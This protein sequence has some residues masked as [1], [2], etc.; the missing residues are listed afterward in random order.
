LALSAEFDHVK[1]NGQV[2][3]GQLILLGIVPA[4][5][6]ARFRAGFVTSRAVGQAVVRNRVRRRL[7][8]IVR[9]HQREIVDQ[10][11]IVT[12][13]R[14]NAARASYQQLEVE[15]LRLAKRASILAASC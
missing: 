5:D 1:K 15:W 8:E 2:Y 9:K 6:G 4:T 7:R 10:I 12:I 3:R 13:A 11:W 14:A